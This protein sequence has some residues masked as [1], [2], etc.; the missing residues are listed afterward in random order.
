MQ[1]P[2][3]L[4]GFGPVYTSVISQL[5]KVPADSTQES[6][7]EFLGPPNPTKPMADCTGLDYFILPV[8]VEHMY[9]SISNLRK[10]NTQ[11][12]PIQD[13]AEEK[14]NHCCYNLVFI[15]ANLPF[16]PPVLQP[17]F[18]YTVHKVEEKKV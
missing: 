2:P 18:Y 6:V 1:G 9:N 17:V 8:N 16:K 4:H 14:Q 12:P 15:S 3:F 13:K 7:M 11:K 10:F 5:T